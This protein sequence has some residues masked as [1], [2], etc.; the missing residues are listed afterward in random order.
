MNPAVLVILQLLLKYGPEVAAKA[1]E[2]MRGKDPTDEDWA[3][4]FE[5]AQTPWKEATKE[6]K[7]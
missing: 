3:K 7:D 6:L 1:R 4:V 5:L 2:L